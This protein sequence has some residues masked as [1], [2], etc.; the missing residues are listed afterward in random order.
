MPNFLPWAQCGF[1]LDFTTMIMRLNFQVLEDQSVIKTLLSP[2]G[3]TSVTMCQSVVQLRGEG[4][5]RPEVQ[6]RRHH[7]S[8]ATGG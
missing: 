1:D 8:A 5:R 3:D 2:S 4:A 7:H 6:Q